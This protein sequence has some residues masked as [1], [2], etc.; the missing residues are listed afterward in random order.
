M[1]NLINKL[2]NYKMQPAGI[3]IVILAVVFFVVCIILMIVN[4]KKPDSSDKKPHIRKVEKEH[5]HRK[6][7]RH[8]DEQK[9]FGE[10]GENVV[11]NMLNNIKENYQHVE[12]FNDFTFE[13][14]NGYSSN[15]DHILICTGGMFIIE[16]KANKGVIY[17]NPNDETWLAKKQDYQDVRQFKNPI[18]QNQGHINHLKRMIDT[19]PKMISMV[20]FPEAENINQVRSE[21]VHDLESAKEYIIAK[22]NNKQY[23]N[24]FVDKMTQK[25]LLIKSEFGISLEKHKQ[26]INEKL[27]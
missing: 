11:A 5:I 13:D 18:I 3:V 25:L 6:P 14:K 26:N 22:I 17:G 4:A 16:T 2:I 23:S 27:N 9:A 10:M 15:I 12:V 19:P 7:F 20:I 24:D 21:I 8:F 1:I